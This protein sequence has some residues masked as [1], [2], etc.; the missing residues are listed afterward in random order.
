[1]SKSDV[2]VHIYEILFTLLHISRLTFK[3]FHLMFKQFQR[4]KFPAYCK[5]DIL[6]SLFCTLKCHFSNTEEM[7]GFPGG[8]LVKNPPTDAGLMV[9]SLCQE[10]P[11]D[12]GNLLLYSCLEK[13][14]GQRTL[15]GK[16]VD[17]T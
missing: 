17:T 8:S 1:M 2:F 12:F 9:R 3:F 6:K 4:M 14:H 15:P 16:Q 5:N 7:A 10:D 13:S 11:L